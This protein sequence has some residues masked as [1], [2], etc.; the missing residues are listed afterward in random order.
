MGFKILAINP[1]STSTKV[2]LYD[3]E[4]PSLDLTLRRTAEQIARYAN[5]IDQLDW[6]REMIL[7]ALSE[8]GFDIMQL[9]AVIGRG[10]LVRPIPAG[11]YEVNEAMRR[12]L[13]NATMEHA[14]NLGG[15][16]AAE[17]AAMAGVKAYIADPVVVDEMEEV[18]RLS[19]HPDCP[20]RSIFHALN[21]KATA[22]LHCDRIGIVYEKANLV[23]A[24]LGGGIS[25]AAHKQGR[26][27]DVNNALD[28]DGPFAPERA[29]SLPAGEF[30]DLCFSGRYTRREVQKM[31]AGQ[32]GLV[33]HLGTNSMM[34]VSE[35]IAQGDEK[36]R[37]VAE[38][39]CYGISKQIGAMAAAMCGRVDAVI[40][41][42]ASPT[43]SSSC[44]T[45]NSTARSSPPFQSTPARTNSNRWS[46]THWSSSAA[47]SSR[48]STP[49]GQRSCAREGAAHAAATAKAASPGH[50]IRR[51]KRRTARQTETGLQNGTAPQQKRPPD[52]DP[53]D[54]FPVY[55]RQ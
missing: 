27:V 1:G 18:A 29:G 19:G 37:L 9:S 31:Q 6:R 36:A 46:P 45:S 20:R 26:V 5:I 34:Q 38:A 35:R 8:H 42:G 23:V 39:M 53:A 3:E 54:V 11:V 4:R 41:T 10:G 44:G 49:D 55:I 47:P 7:T 25:V 14:S 43:T 13:T 15:L 52:I 2:A 32:G 51:A 17:I 30:A 21:Q 33:A 12:D 28:G 24:H 40:L 48:R 50:R 22:R 16:L